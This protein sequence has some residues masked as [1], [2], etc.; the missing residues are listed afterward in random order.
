M[1]NNPRQNNPKQSN[2][3]QSNPRQTNPRQNSRKIQNQPQQ[4][5]SY[6][7]GGIALIAG[8]G[9]GMAMMYL[10]DPEAGE[11]RRR[12]VAKSASR[13]SRTARD[14]AEAAMDKIADAT[15][16][17]RSHG[18]DALSTGMSDVS[19]AGRGLFSSLRSGTSDARSNAVTAAESLYEAVRDKLSNLG[20][21]ASDQAHDSWASA[22]KVAKRVRHGANIALGRESE[23]HYVGQTACAVG[24][25]ALGAGLVWMFDPRLGRGRRAWLRDKSVHWMKEVSD[26]SQKTGRH[27]RNKMQGTVAE[28]RGYLRDKGMYPQQPETSGSQSN[29]GSTSSNAFGTGEFAEPERT[30]GQSMPSI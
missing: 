3:S 27:L 6:V 28:T 12:M 30:P 25:L 7:G 17:I 1:A 5:R 4:S 10:L 16:G 11:E 14:A 8:A 15:S 29:S 24:S 9:I 2:R 18:A 22:R 19:D 21:D 23:H 26:F 13:A 20:D